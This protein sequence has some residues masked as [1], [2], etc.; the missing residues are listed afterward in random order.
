MTAIGGGLEAV[1][2]VGER[3]CALAVDERSAP[4]VVSVSICGA[5]RPTSLSLEYIS[6]KAPVPQ[7]Y[8]SHARSRFSSMG[9]WGVLRCRSVVSSL[10]GSSTGGSDPF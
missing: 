1:R 10:D 7:L 2:E 3:S 4:A 9:V 5:S 6:S 8:L